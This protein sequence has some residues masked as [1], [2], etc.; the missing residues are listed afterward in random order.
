MPDVARE[1]TMSFLGSE[2]MCR[3]APKN[4]PAAISESPK[5]TVGS[6]DGPGFELNATLPGL[7]PG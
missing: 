6:E 4:A 7:P 2:Q 5:S 1:P 3:T